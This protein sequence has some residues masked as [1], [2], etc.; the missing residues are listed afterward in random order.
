MKVMQVT[1]KILPN[2]QV[3]LTLSLTCETVQECF[4]SNKHLQAACELLYLS[5]VHFAL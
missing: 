3:Q 4:S 2:L 1:F 5:C